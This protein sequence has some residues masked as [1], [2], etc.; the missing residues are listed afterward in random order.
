MEEQKAEEEKE[1]FAFLKQMQT[2]KMSLLKDLVE[3]VQ[4]TAHKH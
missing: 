2:E 3:T 1:N 4:D